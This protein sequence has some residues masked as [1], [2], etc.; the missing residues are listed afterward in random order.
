MNDFTTSNMLASP[1]QD[2]QHNLK[3]STINSPQT[4]KLKFLRQVLPPQQ[5]HSLQ[6]LNN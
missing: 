6:N 2:S 4:E 5:K 1:Q 3:L